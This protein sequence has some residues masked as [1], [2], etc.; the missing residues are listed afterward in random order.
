MLFLAKSV[1]LRFWKTQA[2]ISY[3]QC[4]LSVKSKLREAKDRRV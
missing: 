3:R 1:V 4:D 2:D